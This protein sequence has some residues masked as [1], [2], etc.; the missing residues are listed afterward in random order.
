MSQS[1]GVLLVSHMVCGASALMGLRNFRLPVTAQHGLTHH[2]SAQRERE[3]E[4][5][6]QLGEGECEGEEKKMSAIEA[7]LFRQ[8]G[9]KGVR[10]IEKSASQG[11]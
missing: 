11:C 7:E 3:R 2:Q 8:S 1:Q 9:R 10:R 5:A 6:Q 4:R